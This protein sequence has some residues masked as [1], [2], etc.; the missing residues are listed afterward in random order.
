MFCAAVF[1]SGTSCWGVPVPQWIC[2]CSLLR[3]AVTWSGQ[4]GS[5]GTLRKQVAE[6]LESFPAWS[7][8]PIWFAAQRLVL[9][10]GIQRYEH[11]HLFLTC[12]HRDHHCRAWSSFHTQ[13]TFK[14]PFIRV[15][16]EQGTITLQVII[17]WTWLKITSVI[18]QLGWW[19]SVMNDES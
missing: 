18:S 11:T 12:N 3:N 17:P 9:K 1:L 10:L 13:A 4:C 19:G 6:L 5:V 2:I 7:C 15:F 8:N 14:L 16:E